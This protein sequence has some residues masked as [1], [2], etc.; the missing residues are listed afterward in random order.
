MQQINEPPR[1]DETEIQ[2][3]GAILRGVA[4]SMRDL[5][6]SEVNLFK[7]EVRKSLSDVGDHLAQVAIFGGLAALA[8]IPFLAFLVIG[9]GLLLGGNYWLS[10]LLVSFVCAT[11]GGA[12]AYRS[13]KKL[14]SLDLSLPESREGI[15]QGKEVITNTTETREAVS[16]RRVA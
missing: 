1:R 14:K 8:L 12:L 3:F 7:A 9:L 11:V 15:Q 6:Q 13:L 5:V 4:S 16:D 2:S 10:S